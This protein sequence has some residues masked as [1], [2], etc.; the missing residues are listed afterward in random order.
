MAN[1]LLT[2][3]IIAR[4]AIAT[5][6]ENAVMPSLV[7]RDLEDD[8]NTNVNGYRQGQTVTVRKPA[9]FTS[10]SFARPAGITIQDATETS[11]TVTIDQFEEVSFALNDEERALEIGEFNDRLIV[12]AMEALWQKLDVD[13][14]ALRADVITATNTVGVDATPPTDP[15]I[16]VD[17]RKVMNENKVPHNPRYAVWSPL[18]EANFLKDPLFHQADQRGDT[19]GLREASIGRKFGADHFMDQNITDDDGLMFHPHAFVLAMRPLPTNN[20]GVDSFAAMY[21]G[22]SLRTTI[23]YDIV[24]KQEVCSIDMLYGVKTLDADKAVV[25]RG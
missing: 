6:Y 24:Q 15:T 22:L 18:V 9:T 12:P 1:T 2:A 14:L 16:I 21:K 17:A 13:L 10:N 8:F 3:S 20:S 4:A 7:Y 19:T 11:E 23:G 25:I 5:L